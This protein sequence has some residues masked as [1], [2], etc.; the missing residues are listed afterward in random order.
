M[1]QNKKILAI[2]LARAGSK[3]LPNKNILPLNGKPLVQ[4][5]LDAAENSK[6]IDDII[7]TTDSDKFL[8]TVN[9]TK[10]IKQKRDKSLAQDETKSMDVIFNSIEFY[11]QNNPKPDYIVVLQPTS[12]LRN[13]NHIDE[14]IELMFENN[15]DATT[16][17]CECEHSP[18]W[19][20]TLD[21]NNS[22]ENFLSDSLKTSRSQ[23]LPIYYRLNGALSIC[24]YDK[25]YEEGSFFIKNKI[26]AYK[27]DQIDSV[28]I[29][30]KLDFLLAE[31]IMKNQGETNE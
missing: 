30:T 22:M 26:V 14:A 23:D 15:M 10:T 4:W 9:V 20:N 18:L 28:D 11:C 29:D 12:P 17:V 19:S 13:A 16:S 8:E 24:K 2:V 25:L 6:Y 3:R 5:T 31:T 7:F 27:M 1:F 21:E